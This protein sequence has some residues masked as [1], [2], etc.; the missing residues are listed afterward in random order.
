MVKEQLDAGYI[1][2]STSPRN[3]PIFVIK[4]K[5]GKWRLLQDLRAVNKTVLL[6]GA[7]QP[8]LP[9]PVA[10][11]KHWHLI[12]VDLR[13]CFFTIPLH[14]EDSPRF[15]F[16]VPSENLKEPYQRYQ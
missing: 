12:V 16:S 4:K 13:D 15:A 6:M 2:P 8:G 11:P 3:S 1:I 14:P 7:T 10:I 5:S 9:A